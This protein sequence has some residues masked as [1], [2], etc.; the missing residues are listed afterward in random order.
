MKM[1]F[2]GMENIQSEKVLDRWIKLQQKQKNKN[3][4][5]M[6][7]R[8]VIAYMALNFLEKEEEKK[9]KNLFYK[10]SNGDNDCVIHKENFAKIVKE[11]NGNYTDKDIDILFHKLDENENGVIEYEELVRGFSDREK[12]LSERNMK[13]AFNFFD[14]DKD[15]SINWEEISKVVFQNKKMPK[16]FMKEFLEEIEQEKGK[17]VN[18]TFEDFCKIIKSE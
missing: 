8:A 14:K 3:K 18:I 4:N 9:M 11:V 7:K 6:F 17:D 10:L 12:L 5:G 13:E 15:G 1:L 2:G 16:I